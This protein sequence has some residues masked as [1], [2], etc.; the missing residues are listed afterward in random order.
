MPLPKS[1]ELFYGLRL[2]EEQFTYADSIVDYLVTWCQARAGSGK[3]TVA[4]GTA[5]T[6]GKDVHYIFP[7]VE[8][9]ALGFTTGNER[10]KES[11]YLTPLN[12]AI[13]VL[14]EH[15]SQAIIGEP[16]KWGKQDSGW[17][18]A[19]SHNYMRGGNIK[20]SVVIIDEAQN[21]TKRELRKILTRIHDSCHVVVMGDISQCDID[22]KKSGFLPYITHYEGQSFS[23]SVELTKNFRG[24]IS[25]HAETI[26]S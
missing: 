13:Q 12:D 5:K 10:E 18:H 11:K 21:L 3:T 9:G 6:M 23:N 8:E 2:T 4:L 26:G 16:T 14:G 15:P 7:T 1:A 22:P 20:D 19:Y 25:G 24:V 17:I